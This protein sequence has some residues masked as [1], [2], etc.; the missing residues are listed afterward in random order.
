MP[1]RISKEIVNERI[2]DRNIRLV[3]QYVRALTKTTFECAVGHQWEA[4]PASIMSGRGCPHCPHFSGNTRLTKDIVNQR[5]VDRGFRLVG[6]YVKARTK[7]TFEC[8]VGHQWEATP[9]NVMFGYGCPQCY[10]N[11]PLTKEI[12]N[13][14]IVDR[15]IRLVGDYVN[16]LTKTTFECAK[17][18]QWDAA[19][20]QVMGGSGCPHCA[21]NA[22]LTKDIVNKRIADRNIR[23]VGE[24]VNNLVKTTFECA[25]GH[26]WEATPAHVM[27][28]NGCPHCAGKAP[29]TK[30]IVN[31]RIADWNRAPIEPF[32]GSSYQKGLAAV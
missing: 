30:D 12:V 25:E 6:E 5:I 19:P 27:H 10:G 24:Y 1:S 20:A 29:L 11:I 31:E 8:A 7:T 21:G 16:A 26:K 18:H 15:G 32:G 9:A 17:R 2:A 22:H 28:D 23:L 3:G 14:R 4:T 13:E